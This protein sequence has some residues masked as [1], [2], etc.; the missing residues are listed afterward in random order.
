MFRF[1]R[2]FLAV[3]TVAVTLL[4]VCAYAQDPFGPPQAGA[5][6]A[7]APNDVQKHFSKGQQLMQQH[8]VDQAIAEFQAAKKL[9]PKQPAILLN[10]GLC[11]AQ[12]QNLSAA[13]TAFREVIALDPKG[14]TPPT[15]FALTRLSGVLMAQGKNAQALTIA[16]KLA[17]SSPKDYDAQFSLGICYLRLKNF[18]GAAGAFKSALAI[19][20]NDPGALQN[21]GFA[22]INGKNFPEA[23]KLFE[24]TLRQKDDPQVRGMAAYACEQMGDK[25]AALAHYDKLAWKRLP[26]SSGAVMSMVRIYTAMNKP[27]QSNKVLKRAAGLYKNDYAINSNLGR[28]FL[29]QRKYKEAETYLLAA[30]KV[31]SDA[32]VNANLAIADINLNK[33]KNAQIYV[34]AALKQDPKNK[35]T[36]DLYAYILGANNKND[37]AIAQYRK[38]AQYYPTD[39]S[40]YTKIAN[41]LVMQSKNDEAYKEYEKAMKR[42]PKDVSIIVS[43]AAARKGAGKMDEAVALLQ[44]AI[45]LEPKNETPMGALAE[46]YEVQG[47]TD[48]AIEQYKKVIAANPKSKQ[49]IGRLAAAYDAKKDYTSEIAQYRKLCELDPKDIQSAI[50]VARVYDKAEQLDNALAEIKKVAEANPK[51]NSAHAYYGDL[52]VKKKDWTGALAQYGELTKSTET[53]WKSYGY[54]LIGGAQEQAAKPDEAIAAYKSCLDDVPSNRQALDSLAKVYDDQKKPDEF[55]AY[56]KTRIETGKDDMPYD[57]FIT[58]YKDAKKADEALKTIEPLAQKNAASQP[59]QLALASAYKA[60]GQNDKAITQYK[61][62]IAKNKDDFMTHLSLVDLYRTMNKDEDAVNSLNELIKKLP[63]YIKLRMDLGDVYTKMG[64]KT[65]AIAAY[66]AALRLQPGNPEAKG[67]IAFL[68]NPPAPGAPKASV[69]PAAPVIVPIPTPAPGPTPSP[70][71][72]PVTPMTA[73]TPTP[74]PGPTPSPA[75]S[76]A[77]AAAPAAK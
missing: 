43:A 60:A 52:L 45:A 77:P 49:A 46:V 74:A 39:A 41:I 5:S 19:K 9:A 27:D 71:P 76:P 53:R 26:Q 2:V 13:E 65:E 18:S 37:Q 23:R 72:G 75:P 56:L 34:E 11:Y 68:R 15:K 69:L 63:D 8:K 12:K 6:A 1:P 66:N 64:K 28:A 36:I 42:A 24:K 25:Q 51:D 33:T 50:T 31:H 14:N 16:K 55:L 35:Q 22:L 59:I 57:Y 20:P 10:L 47:K 67:K 58:K 7:Q 3:L 62:V 21:L 29:T 32:F 17:A 54:F 70:A 38:W 73:P 40:P 4:S 48:L 30:R 61:A 44:K